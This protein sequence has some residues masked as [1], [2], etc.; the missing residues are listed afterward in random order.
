MSMDDVGVVLRHR[1]AVPDCVGLVVTPGAVDAHAHWLS[2]QVGDA[3]LA[4]GVTTMVIQDCTGP[5]RT[6]ALT[7]PA[8]LRATWAALED[9]PLDVRRAGARLVR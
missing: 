3:A 8:G 6:S 7:L 5:V 4:G 2:P 9:Q 1:P